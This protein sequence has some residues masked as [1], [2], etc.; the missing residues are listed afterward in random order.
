MDGDDVWVR[1]LLST[2]SLAMQRYEGISAGLEV[3]IQYLHGNIR[4]AVPGLLPEQVFRAPNLTHGALSYHFVELVA[5]AQTIATAENERARFYPALI[6]RK[7]VPDEG[8]GG[9]QRIVPGR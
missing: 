1:Q 6:L 4:V 8:S 9:N 5:L 3:A 2:R 7:W